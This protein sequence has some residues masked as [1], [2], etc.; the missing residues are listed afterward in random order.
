[1]N[2]L[3]RVLLLHLLVLG[4]G[5]LLAY[6][7][8]V[9]VGPGQALDDLAFESRKALWLSVRRFA[10]R[11]MGLSSRAILVVGV[12]GILVCARQR[13]SWALP[14]AVVV[15][16]VA[17]GVA[18][19]LLKV[20]L[21]RPELLEFSWAAQANSFP[22]GHSA[23]VTALSL[24]VVSLAS[25]NGRSAA[26]VAAAL[27]VTPQ[28]LVL[29]ASGWHRPSDVAG[30]LLLGAAAATCVL[31]WAATGPARRDPRTLVAGRSPLL[32]PQALATAVAAVWV[33]S[34]SVVLFR[35]TPPD[36]DRP[37]LGFYLTAACL[38]SLA[39]ALIWV[40]A[41]LVELVRSSRGRPLW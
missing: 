34:A 18:A 26:M 30:G 9:H 38:G 37:L 29:A 19:R 31:V 35:V 24:G 14:V 8:F 10:T 12:V 41:H 20:V 15:S 1:M 22:S 32:S 13:R 4:L 3:L 2:R 17:A 23:T 11:L 39:L 7:L 40:H 36:G 27:V 25:S 6:A 5:F 16:V 33:G 28:T 21:V